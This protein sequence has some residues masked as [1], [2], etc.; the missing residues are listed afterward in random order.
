MQRIFS[1]YYFIFFVAMASSQPFLS[2]YLSG[3][4]LG[5]PEIGL[6]LAVG[7]GAGIFAQPMLGYINDRTR[8]PRRILLT[9]AILSPI[10]FAGYSL[11]RQFWP[12]FVVSILVAVVQSSAPIMDAMAVQEGARSGFSYG[13]IRLWGALSFA[14]TTIVAGYVYHDVGIQ[15]SFSVYGALSLIL[16][17][18]VLYLPRDSVFERPKENIFHGVWNVMR[19]PPLIMFI[20]ICFILS[21]AISINSSFLPLYYEGLHY[22]MSWVGANFTVA[23]LVEV[24]LFYISGKLISRVGPMR[25]VILASLLFT[26]KY[27]IMAFA[28]G[29]VIVIL[30]QI[31]D[32]VG[33]AL[34][35]STGVQLVSELAP[36]GRT[37]TAQTLY[38]A[39]ASSLSSV[40]GSSVGGLILNRVGP[41][42]LYVFTTG[43]GALAIVGFLAFARFRF[44][45]PRKSVENCSGEA[46]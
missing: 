15:V 5:S 3:K 32:G 30:A 14:L 21:T 20:V 4:G 42:G 17:V 46:V 27:V 35:W 6:L 16:I 43:L 44:L 31:L 1:I 13:Q 12:L 41:V 39:I 36:E 8:D 37:A 25:V 40:V 23:A 26:V 18:V 28:P 38:G 19:N 34:Y 2:L 45:V 24:P 7:A 22:P 10:M 29:A 9:S 33:Y 11:S